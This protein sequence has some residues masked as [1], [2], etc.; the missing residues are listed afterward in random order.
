VISAQRIQGLAEVLKTENSPI[1]KE[2]IGGIILRGSGEGTSE[3]FVGENK[4]LHEVMKSN[5]N[6]GHWI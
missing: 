5:L 4:D 2:E 3:G 6:P 1:V